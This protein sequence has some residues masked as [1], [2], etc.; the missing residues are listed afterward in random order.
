M[1]NSNKRTKLNK[2]TS[3]KGVDDAIT[4]VNNSSNNEQSFHAKKV[5]PILEE[6]LYVVCIVQLRGNY[7]HE[8]GSYSYLVGMYN[9]KV[10]AHL[11]GAAIELAQNFAA[12]NFSQ[13]KVEYSNQIKSLSAEII[14]NDNA[15]KQWS[16]GMQN[17]RM[18]FEEEYEYKVYKGTVKSSSDAEGLRIKAFSMSETMDGNTR[19]RDVQKQLLTDT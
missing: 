15:L 17:T 6:E 18:A 16:Y 5:A 11:A 1:D 7:I 9:N 19:K 14:E 10:A 13:N 3:S 2:T 12:N 4:T 8:D